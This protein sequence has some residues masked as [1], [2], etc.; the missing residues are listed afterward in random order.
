[1]RLSPYPHNFTHFYV[2]AV[3][4]LQIQFRTHLVIFSLI[5]TDKSKVVQLFSHIWMILAKYLPITIS[6]PQSLKLITISNNANV[7]L[8]LKANG[9][10]YNITNKVT[11][12]KSSSIP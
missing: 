12:H 9:Q 10:H 5:L 8:Q 2:T 11:E 3:K 1:M 6:H 4:T 7:I